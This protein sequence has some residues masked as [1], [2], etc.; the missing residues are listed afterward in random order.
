[1]DVINVIRSQKDMTFNKELIELLIQNENT[2][3]NRA[4]LDYFGTQKVDLAEEQALL[5]LQ[6]HLEDYE[7]STNL[8]LAAVSYLGS[9]ESA[10]A[11]ALFYDLLKDNDQTLASAALRGIGKLKD[12]SRVDEIMELLDEYSGDSEYQDFSASAI[13]VLGELKYQKAQSLM[14]NI[15]QD[16]DAPAS[17]RQFSAIA[18]GQLNKSE[19]LD[20]LM[21]MY[22]ASENSLLRSYILKGITE[23]EGKEVEKL[24]LTALRDS[25]WRI[26]VAASEGLAERKTVEA[27]DIL[28]YKVKKDPV[29]QVRYSSLE[30]LAKIN[31][32]QAAE[33]II[34]QFEGERI[35]FDIRQKALSLIVEN[36]IT[37]S[38]E[39][40][41]K[42]FEPK[43]GIDKDNEL[44]PFCKILS[45]SEWESLKPLFE[46]MLSHPDYIV[47]IYGIR[48]AK[49]NKLS[50]LKE[51][52]SGLDIEGQ[53][54]NVRREAKAALES[55]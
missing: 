29:R 31:N 6:N 13:L 26:R 39:S 18:L 16:E 30:A 11:A 5:L 45:T 15:L 9:I 32:S 47:K 7:Y 1:L 34:S 36:K 42:F 41:E 8:L 51:N 2:E 23:F 14:E 21:S 54:I 43:W 33:F 48:G 53:Q 4:I 24:L 38:I 35:P 17:Q 27:V 46:K 10:D 40:L 20:L 25:F 12:D 49:L 22:I 19:S 55:F 52:I 28:E 50:V 3:I 37:G 44:A